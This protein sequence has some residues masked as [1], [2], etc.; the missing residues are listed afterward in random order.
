MIQIQLQH[1]DF[2][3]LQNKLHWAIHGQTAAEL[4][5]NRADSDQQN[6]GLKTWKDAPKG[7]IQKFDVLVA[8]NYLTQTELE[9]LS[10]LV[11]AYLDLAERASQI[12]FYINFSHIN[13]ANVEEIN[14]LMR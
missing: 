3:Q 2:M 10:R 4:I 5:Y 1:K 11:S 9:S 14:E 6:M 13:N 8:K 12:K 7:K